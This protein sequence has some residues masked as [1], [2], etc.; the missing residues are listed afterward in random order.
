MQWQP[1]CDSHDNNLQDELTVDGT[2][3]QVLRE[4]Y[5]TEHVNG[6]G[7]HHG[8]NHILVNRADNCHDV[9]ALNENEC[10]KRD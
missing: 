2:D 7:Q 9:E 10:C 4:G 5:E 1:A 8:D 6:E 3:L